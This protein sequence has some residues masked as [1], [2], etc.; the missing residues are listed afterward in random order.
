VGWA[1]D[2]LLPGRMPGGPIGSVLTGIVGA[3]LGQLL[4]GLLHLPHLGPTLFRIELIPAF[5]GSLVVVAAAQFLTANR[6]PAYMR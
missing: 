1:A 2:A 6:T 4:F 5:V 3:F